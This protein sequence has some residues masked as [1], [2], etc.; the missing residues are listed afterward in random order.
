MTHYISRKQLLASLIEAIDLHNFLLKD[1]HRRTSVIAYQIGNRY[2][3]A[4]QQLNNLVLAASL[5]DI[6]ALYISERDQLLEVDMV[7]PEPHEQLGAAMLQDF[8]PL[9][10]ISTILRHHHVHYQ[11]VSNGTLPCH[12]VPI[13]C[14]F[15]HLADRIDVLL[16]TAPDPGDSIAHTIEAIRARFGSVFAPF[17]QKT[18]EQLAASATFWDNIDQTCFRD[19]LLRAI[20]EDVVALEQQD[21]DQ[22]ALIFARMVDLKSPWTAA[23]SE[24]VGAIAYRL[25]QLTGLDEQIC[26]DLKI[27][28]Y[29]HDIGKIGIATELLEKPD[30]LEPQEYTHVQQHALYS[31]WILSTIDGLQNIATYAANHHERRD[32]SGYPMLLHGSQM[33]PEMDVIAYADI[34]SALTETRPY[35][36]ALSKKTIRSELAGF[37]PGKLSE[38]VC[39][40]LLNHFDELY[41]LHQ[42]TAGQTRGASQLRFWS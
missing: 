14:F 8:A 3:L 12:E 11:D 33:T 31:S 28:G 30:Q 2:G 22:L 35:R 21:L 37:A 25:G 19:L 38:S 27:A 24:C 17:L 23:H 7:H 20:P 42:D 9:Q 34:F 10:K 13:E 16:T 5:H 18:F 39:R 29:L 6:G 26:Y 41:D 36:P 4:P 32:Q 15:L 1:H 40:T